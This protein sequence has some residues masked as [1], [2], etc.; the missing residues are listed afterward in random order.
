MDKIST[1]LAASFDLGNLGTIN[2]GTPKVTSAEG[3][4][5]TV[6]NWLL[7]LGGTLAVVA[8]IYSGIIYITAGADEAKAENAK[9]NLVWAIT[10]I[11]V[12]LLSLVLINWISSTVK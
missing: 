4:I 11:V 6:I 12:I 10:G 1:K 2:L 3:L 9:K 8:I 5:V 7:A